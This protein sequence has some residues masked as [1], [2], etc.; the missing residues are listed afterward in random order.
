[1][2]AAVATAWQSFRAQGMLNG[3]RAQLNKSAKVP[4]NLANKEHLAAA[5]AILDH[6]PSPIQFILVAPYVDVRQMLLTLLSN[7]FLSRELTCM[8]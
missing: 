2:T 1:M 5:Q 4:F 3:G 8:S 6:R 7:E